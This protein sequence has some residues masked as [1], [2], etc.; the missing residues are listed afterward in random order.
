M[1]VHHLELFYYVAKHGGVS[2]AAR[3]M[4]Y[5]I[6]QPAISAQILQLE[7]SLG[8][9]LFNRRPFSLTKE[10]AELYQFVAPFFGGL[11]GLGEKLRGGTDKR[12]RISTPE[13]V[14][15][16][17]LPDLLRRMRARVPGFQFSLSSGS[18]E[19]IIE[20][21]RAQSV[22]IGVCTMSGKRPEGVQRRD[23][24]R[25]PMVLLVQEKSRI[26]SAAEIL[27]R[28]RIDLPLVA[29]H[30]EEPLSRLFQ[31]ELQKR[32]IDWFPAVEVP[33]PGLVTR[34]VLE[35]FGVGLAFG[36][37]GIPLA[38]G[39]RELPLKGFPQVT[40]GAMW[41]GR[42]TPLGALFV[43]EAAKLGKELAAPVS[44]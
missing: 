31:M 9:T 35:G 2:A 14:Q 21:L 33:G 11:A 34:Y 30:G 7:D 26:T 32:K 16:D 10:G 38:R 1:N 28:D 39:L 6:Q 20:Q 23:L 4:P 19:E 5:G 22:E 17:Y 40:F 8:R 24:A 15:R 12:L 25:L 44:S 43:E 18:E 37:P 36:T 27:G 3:L 13:I 29:V 41:L 42:L